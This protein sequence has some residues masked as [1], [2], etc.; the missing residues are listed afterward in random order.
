VKIL[1]HHRTQSKDGQ[2]VHIEELIQALREE[3]C[4]VIVVEPHAH[5][6][7]KFGGTSRGIEA[8]KRVLPKAVYEALELVYSVVAYRKLLAAVRRHRPDALYE[9]SNLFLLAGAWL[10]RRAGVPYLLEVNAPLYEERRRHG[11]LALER[12]ACWT[13]RHAWRSADAVLPVSRALADIVAAAGVPD[14][15]LHVIPNAINAA[16]FAELPARD[17]AKERLGLSGKLVLGFAGFVRSWHGLDG[18]VDLLAGPDGAVRHL[19]VVGDGPARRD[20]E[21]RALDLGIAERVTVTGVVERDRIPGLLAA[22]DIALQPAATSY[23]SPLKLFEYMACG[24]AI[25]APAQ[26]NVRE[27]LNDGHNALLFAPGDLPAMARAVDRLAR[28]T[29][30][31]ER[32]AAAARATLRDRRLTWRENARRVMTIAAELRATRAR[33]I[34]TDAAPL[35]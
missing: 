26:P 18:V 23:A 35:R 20:I 10:R 11:G 17:A 21:T 30:L 14:E 3:G 24:C 7:A 32:L 4:E 8:L 25:V 6:E 28:D 29:A 12:I 34:Q 15:R 5:R 33:G 19:L 16:R 22:F 31:R 2:A 9:R 27:L 1:Y 13:E